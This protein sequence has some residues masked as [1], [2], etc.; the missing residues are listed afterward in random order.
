MSF[1]EGET[2]IYSNIGGG[3]PIPNRVGETCIILENNYSSSLNNYWVEFE[4]GFTV[5][6]EEYEISKLTNK[7]KELITYIYKGNKVI[8]TPL[9]ETVHVIKVDYLYEQVEIEHSDN[10]SQV[11]C[12]DALRKTGKESDSLTENKNDKLGY[13]ADLG[14]SVGK[15]V[16][17]KQKAYG[18]SVTKCYEIMKVLLND[19]RNEESRTYTIPESLIPQMLLDIR[20]IDKMNRRFSNPDGDLMGENSFQDD[21]GYSLLGVRMIEQLHNAK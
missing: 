4:D 15:L 10:S 5:T 17:E 20:K 14:L 21:V 7:Q 3:I 1:L 6:V 8:Y 11:V 12:F 16:D 9:D 19:Y 18:D 2:C 13:F